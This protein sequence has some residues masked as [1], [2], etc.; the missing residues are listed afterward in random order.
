MNFLSSFNSAPRASISKARLTLA[1]ISCAL[2]VALMFM[3]TPRSSGQLFDVTKG[4]SLDAIASAL[5]DEHI[6]ASEAL[7]KIVV[8]AIGGERTIQAGLYDFSH[9]I[10]VVGVARRLSQGDFG[11]EPVS[12][13]FPEGITRKQIVEKAAA[14]LP[15]FDGEAFMTLAANDEGYLFPDTYIFALHA[16]ANEVRAIMRDT[17]EEKYLSLATSTIKSKLSRSEIV[18]L[19]SIL[20]GEAADDISR[21]TVAGILLKRLSINMPLQVDAT[22]VYERDKNSSELTTDDLEKDSP[23]NSYTR[24]GLPPTPISNPGLEAIHAV[25]SPI[26]SPY[27]YFL[28]APDGT[29]HY[30]RTFDDHLINKK[31]YLK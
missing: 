21:R 6:V 23:Y 2:F 7:F 30:A 17:F 26:T 31:R 11:T 19:A 25:L 12:L 28:T 3:F 1:G 22:F 18:T 16:D 20:E 24:R 13:T 9:P 5:A 10:S 29:T 8:T 27:L 4:E 14:A 15:K